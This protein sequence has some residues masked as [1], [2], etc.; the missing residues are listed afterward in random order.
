LP[1]NADAAA[2]SMWMSGRRRDSVNRR[3]DVEASQPRSGA[4]CR[5]C[6]AMFTSGE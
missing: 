6:H 2:S 1:C 3:E 4:P 5:P